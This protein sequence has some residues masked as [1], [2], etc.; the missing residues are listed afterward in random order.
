MGIFGTGT[1]TNSN[2]GSSQPRQGGG[3][4]KLLQD[5]SP[6]IP[7]VGG[8]AS[9]VIAGINERKAR[10]YN[11]PANQ[12]KRL[13]E[14][15]LPLAAGS[16][17]TAGGGVSTKV[18]DLGTGQATQNLGASI[19]RSI[20]R[21]KLEIM[22]QELRQQQY[23]ADIAEGERNNK[24][25]PRG[26]FENTNQGLSAEQ[27]IGTQAEALKSA[28]VINKFMPSEKYQALMKGTL[29]MGKL[30]ADTQNALA[31]NKILLSEGKIKAI[32]ARYQEGMSLQ[33][34]QGLIKSNAGQDLRN[35]GMGL[36][37][38]SKQVALTIEYAT[39][40]DQIKLAH[41]AAKAS[42]NNLEA[43]RLSLL[44][45][46]LSM[47]STMAYYKIRREMDDA[48]MRKPNLANTILYLGMFQPTNSNYNFGQLTNSLK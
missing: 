17:I 40:E 48:T 27:T 19:T 22:Q 25:N 3:F 46:N 5:I 37:N 38:A 24:L 26:I 1:W 41:N 23:A 4:M 14:A 43:Q 12:V 30:S 2:G 31:Q 39:M 45:T 47:P 28:Q 7:I 34:L 21:K 42:D 16:N 15:G 9:N 33:Q 32:L 20:D 11:T 29:E 10:L 13:Q 6:A 44:L 8:I 36:E 35:T 18:S